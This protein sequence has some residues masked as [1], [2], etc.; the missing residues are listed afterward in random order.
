MDARGLLDGKVALVHRAVAPG[1]KPHLLLEA[2]SGE[3]LHHRLDGAVM[4]RGIDSGVF[5]DGEPDLVKGFAQLLREP[6]PIV[7]VALEDAAHVAG[8]NDG[9]LVEQL[10]AGPLGQVVGLALVDLL[11]PDEFPVRGGDPL[12]SAVG[13]TT[14]DYESNA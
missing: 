2:R 13:S 11:V 14:F 1:Q 5:Q 6:L 12:L 8:A 3:H 9:L 4:Q 10:L 7:L